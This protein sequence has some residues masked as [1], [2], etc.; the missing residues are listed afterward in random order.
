MGMDPG[1]AFQY[2]NKYNL[3]SGLAMGSSKDIEIVVRQAGVAN[4]FIT[5]EKQT[6][7]NVGFD[8]YL[9]NDTFH[10]NTEFFYNKR[11]DILAPRNASVPDYTGLQIPDENIA[12]VRSEERSV[13]KECVGRCRS[14]WWP[15][16]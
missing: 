16:H 1:A 11:S 14:R 9:F 10:L 5:W 15:V 2:M 3:A 7:Y 8:S 13:G 12:E 4:P 6:T